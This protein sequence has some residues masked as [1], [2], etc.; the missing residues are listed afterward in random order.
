MEGGRKRV[1]RDGD[2]TRD[3]RDQRIVFHR[4]KINQS[5]QGV[6]RAEGPALQARRCHGSRAH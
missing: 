2:E 6:P 5:Q 4:Q 3:G 1:R